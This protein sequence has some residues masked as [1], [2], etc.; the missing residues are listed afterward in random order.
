MKRHLI[1]WIAALALGCVGVA[2]AAP[3]AD[4]V[5]FPPQAANFE[6][7][8][9]RALGDAVHG[10]LVEALPERR[11]VGPA[12]AAEVLG[13]TGTPAAAVAALGAD[14]WIT[15]RA[16]RLE[17]LSEVVLTRH[18]VDLRPVSVRAPL[19]EAAA[20]PAAARG[21]IASL[22]A[23]PDPGPEPPLAADR[24]EL[25]RLT[26]GLRAGGAWAAWDGGGPL[27]ALEA[28]LHSRSG[29][30][31]VVGAIAG[32]LPLVDDVQFWSVGAR[33]RSGLYG[34]DGPVWP[35][36]WLGIEPRMVIAPAEVQFGLLPVI[37]VGIDL[38]G[39]GR[40]RLSVDLEA[41]YN[42][43][44]I[45]GPTAEP[46]PDEPAGPDEPDDADAPIERRHQVE[47]GL[48]LGIGW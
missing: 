29:R 39:P 16:I 40:A 22:L 23:A 25:D 2:G 3:K 48:L 35:A 20:W 24:R 44:E 30:W 27:G 12:R 45:G 46:E 42:L 21:W 15:C 31:F 47:I 38:P 9:A 14:V 17:A 8:F 7:E 18:R 6:P 43:V 34:G 4:V 28:E 32:R 33:L 41:G 37:G 10:A 36:L 5:V 11:I 19:P 1:G 13:T 26:W